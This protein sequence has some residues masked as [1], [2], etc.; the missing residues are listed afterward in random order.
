[1]RTLTVRLDSRTPFIPHHDNLNW[2]DEMESWKNNPSNKKHSRAG[3]DRSPAFRWLGSLYHD[4]EVLAIPQDNIMKSFMEGAAMVLVP[5]GKNGKTFKA[6][7]QSGML[8]AEPY[9]PLMIP[10][11]GTGKPQTIPVAPLLALRDELDFMKHRE[12]VAAMGFELFLK[13]AKIG[14]S[15]HVRVRPR[16]DRWSVTGTVHVWDDQITDAVLTDI[17]RQA[18][19]YKGI[20]DWRASSPKSPGPY[21]AFSA[22]IIS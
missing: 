18:G 10:K 2:A 8:A 11:N 9:W 3:D 13:R 14:A 7:S 21:G 19:L 1:M 12:T 16:F 22:S 6:Q 4:G 20:G 5:G 15:K 17:M